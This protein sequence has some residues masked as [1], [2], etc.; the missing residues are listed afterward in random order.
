MSKKSV[1]LDMDNTL[2]STSILP[3]SHCDFIIPFDGYFGPYYVQIRPGLETLFQELAKNY[4]IIV[5]TAAIQS[6]ADAVLDTL[7]VDKVISLR[8]YRDSCTMIQGKAV[9][10]LAILGR[11]LKN[12]II[13]DDNPF[14]YALQ[15]EN[16]IPVN[17]FVGD[18]PDT[19]LWKVIGMCG[20]AAGYEDVREAIKV[21]RNEFELNVPSR[22]SVVS[23]ME[24]VR[25]LMYELR[26]PVLLLLLLLF[27]YVCLKSYY[28]YQK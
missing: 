5:F 14:S 13:I 28:V 26:G 9:K 25:C 20:I 6:Y 12:V 2:I 8:L 3:I 22:S 18:L 4:E 11:D 15:P 7:D 21:H 10:N 24:N 16:A 17:P 1:V 27:I 23:V 19:E